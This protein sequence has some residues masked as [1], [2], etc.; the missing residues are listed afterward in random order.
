[1]LST[2]EIISIAKAFPNWDQKDSIGI[3]KKGIRVRNPD[4][5]RVFSLLFESEKQADAAIENLRKFSSIL[6]AE[7]NID[8]TL[9]NDPRYLDGTQWYLRNTGANGGIAGADVNA[10][11]AWRIFT[12]SSNSTIAIFDTGVDQ[13][14]EEFQSRITGDAAVEEGHGTMVAG[15]AGARENNSYRVKVQGKRIS[16]P[17]LS[18]HQQRE[19][20][21]LQQQ[22]VFRNFIYKQ[23]GIAYG[24]VYNYASKLKTERSLL[25]LLSVCFP[26]VKTSFCNIPVLFSEYYFR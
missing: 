2:H 23:L 7:K 3:N 22:G 5:H 11:G 13:N 14:H 19:I 18:I 9:F 10:E 21:E 15:I 16:R 8:A 24:I 6:Y 26:F 25:R 17:P 4:F 12:G 1:M 20:F